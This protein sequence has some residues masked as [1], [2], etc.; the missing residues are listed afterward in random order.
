MGDERFQVSEASNKTGRTTRRTFQKPKPAELWRGVRDC[1]QF[2]PRS[3]QVDLPWDY[4]IT[5]VRQEEAECLNLNIFV[6]EVEAPV[7]KNSSAFENCRVQRLQ[8]AE[9]LP[10]MVFLHGGGWLIHSSANYGDKQICRNLCR[11]G[12]VS[13]SVLCNTQA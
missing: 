8:P 1:T 12:V 3:L 9:G 10:I 13:T 2:G 6:P 7:S 4:F 11:H 5:P